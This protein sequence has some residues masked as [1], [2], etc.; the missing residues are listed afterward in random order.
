MVADRASYME[1]SLWWEPRRNLLVQNPGKACLANFWDV[2]TGQ[3]L[4]L[5]DAPSSPKT[6]Y[7]KPEQESEPGVFYGRIDGT[8]HGPTAV[9]RFERQDDCTLKRACVW[10]Y[11]EGW[12]SRRTDVPIL[13]LWEEK[14]SLEE[15]PRG[16]V[17]T[18]DEWEN[19]LVV[20]STL[21]NAE[22][23]APHPRL[24]R[25][26]NWPNNIRSI[27]GCRSNEVCAIARNRCSVLDPKRRWAQVVAFPGRSVFEFAPSWASA[28][29]YAVGLVHSDGYGL[30]DAQWNELRR[31][32]TNPSLFQGLALETNGF[33]LL[34][35]GASQ[36]IKK[37]TCRLLVLPSGPVQWHAGLAKPLRN[38]PWTRTTP[39]LDSERGMLYVDPAGELRLTPW[40]FARF[41]FQ[42]ES[43][44]FVCNE[45]QT[46][47]PFF[48]D[49]LVHACAW[50]LR[51]WAVPK[52]AAVPEELRR[53]LRRVRNTCS[54]KDML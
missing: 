40:E 25:H 14:R 34:R 50:Q 39:R 21:P 47:S 22:E 1:D 19:L 45:T 13:R 10:T 23:N 32:G 7:F 46:N 11:Q 41:F 29:R 53:L 26:S 9:Y 35:S 27:V 43:A 20:L 37:K 30:R 3:R 16:W 5:V 6:F 48:S 24:L 8:H 36:K 2:E 15:T 17:I 38:Q 44:F 4:S 31:V 49:S 54:P 28:A 18:L 42:P 51:D 52:E 33:W 12:L